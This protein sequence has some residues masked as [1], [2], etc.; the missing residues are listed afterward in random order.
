MKHIKQILVGNIGNHKY[1]VQPG[2]SKVSFVDETSRCDGFSEPGLTPP[3][4]YSMSPHVPT[5]YSL[6]PPLLISS[7]GTRLLCS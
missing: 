5:E 7:L 1:R 3:P 2:G 6:L 4:L